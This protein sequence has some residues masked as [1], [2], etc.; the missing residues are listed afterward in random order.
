LADSSKSPRP[1]MPVT[2]GNSILTA[3][4]I[5]HCRIGFK[6]PGHVAVRADGG[7]KAIRSESLRARSPYT[8]LC[9]I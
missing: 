2:C 8:G 3:R 4:A 7:N 1:E 5:S 9:T 6:A